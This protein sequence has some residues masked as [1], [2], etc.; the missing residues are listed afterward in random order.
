MSFRDTF[1]L[2]NAYLPDKR[3]FYKLLLREQYFL[4]AENSPIMSVKFMHAVLRKE[5]YL[6]LMTEVRPIRLGEQPPKAQIKAELLLV[7]E[8]MSTAEASEKLVA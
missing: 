5:I 1:D 6:P 4:P 2:V 3:A 8:E 7:M